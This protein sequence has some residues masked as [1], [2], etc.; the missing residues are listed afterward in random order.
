MAANRRIG[1]FLEGAGTPQAPAYCC[2]ECGY[3][4]NN[5]RNFRNAES[6]RTCSTG[7]YTAANGDLK[8]S[9]NPYARR[10]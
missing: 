7:H 6:G 2:A 10:T 9:R 1:A 3:A 5:H 8:R 4:S